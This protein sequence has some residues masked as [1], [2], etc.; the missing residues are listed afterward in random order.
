MAESLRERFA[1]LVDA[2]G[3]HHIWTGAIRRDTGAGRMKVNG[4]EVQAR[5]VAWE[6][7]HGPLT[8]GARVLPCPEAAAC[9]RLDHLRT[10]GADG[11]PLDAVPVVAAVRGRSRRGGGSMRRVG[12]T[13]WDFV[14][15]GGSIGDERSRAVRTWPSF[16]CQSFSR[17]LRLTSAKAATEPGG[18]VLTLRHRFGGAAAPPEASPTGTLG[19][20][21][22][23]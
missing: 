16:D 9:V 23:P 15:S 1:N 12:A 13:T 3:E 10:V 11:Q 14:V 17:T 21:R 7:E 18:H 4:K 2:S 8:Q 20:R 6:L 5:Q 19:T 22:R